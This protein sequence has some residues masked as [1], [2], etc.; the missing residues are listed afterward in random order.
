M[1]KT[2]IV[3]LSLVITL[4]L[5]SCALVY[6]TSLQSKLITELEQQVKTLKKSEPVYIYM[7]PQEPEMG[8]V[9]PLRNYA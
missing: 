1:N 2:D 3:G 8:I 4:F 9:D 6:E 7:C 5:W